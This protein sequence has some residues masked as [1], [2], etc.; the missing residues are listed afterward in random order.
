MRSINTAEIR[1]Q[2]FALFLK[3][4]SLRRVASQLQLSPSRLFRWSTRG[5]WVHQRAVFQA[6]QRDQFISSKFSEISRKRTDLADE[7]F[8]AMAD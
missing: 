6:G 7:V 8:A 5:D 4:Y 2:A 3:G 1:D